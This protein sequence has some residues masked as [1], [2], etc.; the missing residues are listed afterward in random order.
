MRGFLLKLH[1]KF[2]S[3]SFYFLFL[4]IIILTISLI[5]NI[6]YVGNARGRISE[7]QQKLEQL[8]EEQSQ[9]QAELEKIR[10]RSYLE[11]QIRDKLNLVDKGEIVLVLPKDD[12]LKQFSPR[13]TQ[14]V[15]E[16]LPPPNWKAWLELFI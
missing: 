12:V 11:K 10:S 3:F 16:F 5:R 13:E 14:E 1:Q 2:G 4:L 8:Q 6:I 7:A 9:L 15:E